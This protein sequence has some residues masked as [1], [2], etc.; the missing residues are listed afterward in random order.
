LQQQYILLTPEKGAII[1]R[2]F[3]DGAGPRA[4][5]VGYPEKAHLAFDANDMCIR[6]LWQGD[7]IDASRHWTDRG[8]GFQGPAGDN[9]LHLGAGP[10]LAVLSR[11]DEPWPAQ[12]AKEI[13]FRFRGY[14]LTP[15]DRPTFLY[16]YQ[17][18]DIEDFPNAVPGKEGP[19]IRRE[20]T[21]HA[22]SELQGLWFRAAT[23]DKI[24]DLGEGWFRI[25]GEWRLR[26]H[27]GSRPRLRG[28]PG[29]KEVLVP[30]HFHEGIA[31]VV[32]EFV[33]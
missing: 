21:L 15:D 16:S 18:A 31:R 13:G 3:I 8:A 20:I 22:H 25:N 1:Y 19:S 29:K 27:A 24:E 5:A 33:W 26:V 2:N 17:G 23:A 6:L 10:S 9:V 32:Q 11:D 7:F 30:I 12:P 4:I 14:R 28:V